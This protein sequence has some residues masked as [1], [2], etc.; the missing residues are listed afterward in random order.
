ML[1]HDD[2]ATHVF[3]VSIEEEREFP[4]LTLSDGLD[5]YLLH[6]PA[7]TKPLITAVWAFHHARHIALPE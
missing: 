7:F 3:L 4:V 1:E 6:R 5:E 2:L